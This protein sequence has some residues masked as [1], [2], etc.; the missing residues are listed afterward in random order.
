MDEDRETSG[1]GTTGHALCEP[2]F[3]KGK[4][5]T[6]TASERD[7]YL[8]PDLRTAWFDE[9][10]DNESYGKVRGS[11]VLRLD[12]ER[13]RI[14]QYVLSIPV[15]NELAKDLVQRIRERR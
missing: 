2:Y 13:W 9:C 5:W 10:L 7:I 4:G 8:A 1:R 11:G 12:G 3:S 15:P 6:Y 14:T